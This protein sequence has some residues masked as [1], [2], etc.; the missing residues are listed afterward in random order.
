MQTIHQSIKTSMLQEKP[1]THRIQNK[2]MLGN[3]T[4]KENDL[5]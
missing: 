2:R 5:Q 1:D 4:R 3:H